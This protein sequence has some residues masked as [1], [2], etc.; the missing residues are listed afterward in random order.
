MNPPEWLDRAAFPFT[1]R[2]LHHPDGRL[3]Y[4]DEGQGP[5][6]LFCHGTPEWSFGYRHLLAALSGE[7]RCV[8]VDML[9]F[10]LSEK[11]ARADYTV[12][13]HAQ[14]LAWV[15]ETLN[16]RDVTLVANDFGGGLAVDYALRF[17]ENVRALALWNTWAW[18][19]NDDVHFA[20]PARFA[21]T[22]FGRFL[23]KTLNFPVR[24]LLPRAFANRRRLTPGLYRHYQMPFRYR[25]DRSAPYELARELLNA[26]T[27]WQARW[28]RLDALTDKPVL[29]MWGMKDRF[30]PPRFLDTWR[31]RL[32]QA[33][34]MELPETGHFPHEESP[35]AVGAALRAFLKKILEQEF[36]RQGSEASP[37]R[38]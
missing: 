21:Q 30:V 36:P 37:L 1:L 14:R 16:L 17:P 34:V 11:P 29:L 18:A 33:E 31:E 5:T 13:A 20:R 38:S 35:E 15:V 22:A 32:P 7:F 8:A 4:V 9:G 19:L 6:L 23:Y 24:V 12:A 2:T 25:A 27:W 26:G 28:R 3:H 10:G